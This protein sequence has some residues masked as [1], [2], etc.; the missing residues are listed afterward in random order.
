MPGLAIAL[1]TLVLP[2]SPSPFPPPPSESDR[3]ASPTPRP[4]WVSR[5]LYCLNTAW[6]GL[7]LAIAISM[8]VTDGLKNLLGR[9][10]PDLISRCNIDES[11]IKRYTIGPGE[12]LDWRVCR[13]HAV[14]RGSLTG[15]LD[16]ADLRDGFRSFPSGHCSCLLPRF[17]DPYSH[18]SPSIHPFGW[19]MIA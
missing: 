13:S 7:G 11:L 18:P 4:G 9:P 6:L 2:S 16:E 10:R 15:V 5:R 1:L 12:L 8:L 14:A 19:L 3:G 17:P